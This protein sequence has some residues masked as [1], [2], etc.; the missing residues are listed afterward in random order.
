[1]TITIE[2]VS[3]IILGI[4]NVAMLSQIGRHK[5]AIASLMGAVSAHNEVLKQIC[6]TKFPEEVASE[7]TH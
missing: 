7:V 2:M 1:M 6:I 3:I 4:T 5:R